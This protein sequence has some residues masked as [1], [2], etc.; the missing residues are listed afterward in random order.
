FA[1][2]PAARRRRAHRRESSGALRPRRRGP[3]IPD[4]RG[5]HGST[6]PDDGG[7]R[8]RGRTRRALRRPRLRDPLAD[9]G[10]DPHR[11]RPRLPER[12]GGPRVSVLLATT[13]AP[14]VAEDVGSAMHALVTEL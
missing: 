5:Q 14:P 2:L 1:H 7:L 12:R 4:A 3:R 11:P 8:A 10:P 6:L 13:S 9:S